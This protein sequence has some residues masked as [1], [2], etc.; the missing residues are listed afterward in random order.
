[1]GIIIG[2]GYFRWATSTEMYLWL[3]FNVSNKPVFIISVSFSASHCYVSSLTPH[4]MEHN[5]ITT[6]NL[7]KSLVSCKLFLLKSLTHWKHSGC[8]SNCGPTVGILL[9]IIWLVKKLYASNPIGEN[10]VKSDIWLADKKHQPREIWVR[11]IPRE[12]AVLTFWDSSQEHT[13]TVTV[14]V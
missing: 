5:H 2:L 14:E 9:F 3:I 12:I 6:C 8:H 11:A 10:M 13:I 7:K 1:M 4:S